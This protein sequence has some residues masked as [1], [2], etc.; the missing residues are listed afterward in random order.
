MVA[1]LSRA[2]LF[3]M[4]LRAATF[5]VRLALVL[6]LASQL[7]PADV[8]RYSLVAAIVTFG[9]YVVGLNFYTFSTREMAADGSRR[10]GS[11][12]LTQLAL[13]GGIYLVVGPVLWVMLSWILGEPWLAV[14]TLALIAA[15]HLTQEADRILVVAGKALVSSYLTAV[16][17]AVWPVV[18]LGWIFVG[19]AGLQDV[20]LVWLVSDVLVLGLSLVLVAR[21]GISGWS[22]GLR[23]EWG[24]RGLRVSAVLLTSTLAIQA[25]FTLDRF[26]FGVAGSAAALG[27]YGL[28]ASLALGLAAA[29]AAGIHIFVYPRM[30]EAASRDDLTAVAALRRRITHQTRALGLVVLPVGT[31]AVFVLTGYLDSPVY[32]DNFWMFPVLL[33][34]VHGLNE[35]MAWHYALYAFRLDWAQVRT[36]VA[37]V[38]VGLAL[39]VLSV[40]VGPSLVPVGVL[41]GCLGLYV[42]L[43]T[44]ATTLVFGPGRLGGVGEVGQGTKGQP[45]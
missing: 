11:K 37:A 36:T 3:S 28:F 43:R 19:D 7:S 1:T 29:A 39:M 22:D 25:L 15:E 42:G 23:W 10:W 33:L 21:L 2:Q 4:T 24:L 26:L 6:G 45:V 8:G 16:R 44:R 38:A 41:V 20:L 35:A 9:I 32:R 13:T 40:V 27:A 12:V 30:V 14:I 31:V 5:A 34:A 18:V 17:F